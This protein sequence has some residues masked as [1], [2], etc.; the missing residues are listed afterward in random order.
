M[1][2]PGHVTRAEATQ[3]LA[4]VREKYRAWIRAGSGEPALVMDWRGG[5]EGRSYVAITWEE[6]PD[7]WASEPLTQ[8]SFSEEL[9]AMLADF[10]GASRAAA[11]VPGARGTMPAGV[12]AE[13]YCSYVLCLHREQEQDT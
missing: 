13:P 3:V 12:G 8:D 5:R 2:E 4:L 6:G 7:D 11:T 10:P 1:S 9:A